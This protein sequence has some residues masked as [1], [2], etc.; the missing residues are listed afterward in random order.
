MES[1]TQSTTQ[2]NTIVDLAELDTNICIAIKTNKEKCSQ[3]VKAGSTLC[4]RHYNLKMKKGSILDIN[5]MQNTSEFKLVVNNEGIY[6]YQHNEKKKRGRRR[7]Y[8]ISDKFYDDDY[9]TVWPEIVNG[10]KLLVDN[11]NNVYT[12]NFENPEYLGTKTLEAKLIK[13]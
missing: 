6:T 5:S 10:Q 3:R 8:E 12:F 1:N 13:K 7:K 4:N 2:S 11:D 9:I